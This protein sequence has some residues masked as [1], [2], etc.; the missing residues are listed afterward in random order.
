MPIKLT[1]PL[2]L[3][4]IVAEFGGTKPYKL[5]NYYRGG[6]IVPNKNANSKVPLNGEISY[7]DFYGATKIIELTYKAYGGGGAGGS[8]YENGGDTVTTTAEAG[9]KT[10][11]MLKSVYDSLKT[12]GGGVV[13][14]AVDN[15][16]FLLNIAGGNAVVSGGAGGRNGGSGLGR[17][18]GAGG[19]SDFGAGSAGGPL[20]NAAGNPVWGRWASGGGGGGGDAGRG[21]DYFIIFNKGGGDAAGSGG[22]GG[23]AASPTTGVIDIDVEVDYVVR[24][25]GGG[26]PA[27]AVGN[28]D[29]GAGSPGYLEFTIDTQA[30]QTFIFSPPPIIS[31]TLADYTTEYYFGFRINRNGTCTVTPTLNV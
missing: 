7:S 25:G 12:A 5:S 19:N 10:G 14:T 20:N 26:Y 27:T 21:D 17:V 3:S 28:H 6:G 13:P 4:D 8:G 2:T 15:A 31:P 29:G 1:G 11:I 23:A 9:A 16:L 24:I 18:G 30:G 22:L